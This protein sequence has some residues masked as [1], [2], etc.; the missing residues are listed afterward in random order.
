M[1][2]YKR[3]EAAPYCGYDKEISLGKVLS[4]IEKTGVDPNSVNLKL[5]LNTSSCHPNAVLVISGDVNEVS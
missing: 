3:L 4:W 1:K 5:R 2:K